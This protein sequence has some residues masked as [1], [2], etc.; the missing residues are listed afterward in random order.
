LNVPL[1]SR[2]LKLSNSKQGYRFSAL[3]F[4]LEAI[5][6]MASWHQT[7]SAKCI[8]QL[9]LP[10]V[11]PVTLL[12]SEWWFEYITQ[13]A[14]T[15]IRPSSKHFFYDQHP[16]LPPLIPQLFLATYIDLCSTVLCFELQPPESSKR[17]DE[18]H[19]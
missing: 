13:I 10:A 11:R 6:P 4:F 7:Q 14:D 18:P 8:L 1:L 15:G 12:E 19:D 16:T 17:D 9:H 2:G 5:P 3:H